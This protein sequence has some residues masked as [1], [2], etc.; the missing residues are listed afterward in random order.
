MVGHCRCKV[1]EE[2]TG[3]DTGREVAD[4]VQGG[5][6]TCDG[7]VQQLIG[8]SDPSDESGRHSF[9]DNRGEDHHITLVPLKL[10]RRT[11]DQSICYL[12]PPRSCAYSVNDPL[13]LKP[14]RRH[15][16]EV[17]V[18]AQQKSGIPPF[19]EKIEHRLY[20]EFVDCATRRSW[21]CA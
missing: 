1:T 11:H 17:D 6:R 3:S 5:A 16:A 15:D 9:G 19:V 12:L 18:A 10:V 20:L 14:E 4:N 21:Y 13:H 2:S 7:D 8:I